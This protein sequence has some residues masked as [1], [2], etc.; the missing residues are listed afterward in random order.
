MKRAFTIIEVLVVIGIIAILTAI[1]IPSINGTKARNRDSEKI[2]DISTIQLGLQLYYSQ[3]PEGYPKSL[4]QED[5]QKY[6]TSESLLSPNSS[7]YIYIPLKTVGNK[8]I[9]YHLGVELE[10]KNAQIDSA[11]TFSSYNLDNITND[12]Q[13]CGNLPEP[14]HGLSP[15]EKNYNVHP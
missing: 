2:A 11:D 8:C 10:S 15:S 7:S 12:Y 4:E 3:H 9:Y 6:I 5:F 14:E 13:Y 1:I